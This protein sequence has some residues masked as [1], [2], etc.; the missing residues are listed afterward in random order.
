MEAANKFRDCMEQNLSENNL[1]C[2]QLLNYIENQLS[3][4]EYSLDG[5]IVY[6]H[7]LYLV[8][9][10]GDKAKASVLLNSILLKNHNDIKIQN[11]AK[12]QLERLTE[13]KESSAIQEG[14]LR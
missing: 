12:A 8:R 11:E 6:I 2:K 3:R 13:S 14:L 9:L 4:E 1:F 10:S 5:E 7:F